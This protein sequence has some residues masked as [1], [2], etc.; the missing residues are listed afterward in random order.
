MKQNNHKK[1]KRSLRVIPF[2][3]FSLIG[4]CLL[5][6]GIF[7]LTN[8][9][10]PE[11]SS[12][13]NEISQQDLAHAEEALHLMSE[14]GD[15]TWPE[16]SGNIPLLLWNDEYAFLTNSREQVSGWDRLGDA[17]VNHLPVY[18]QK[19]D[20]DYQAFTEILPNG[21][22]AGSMATK[23]ATNIGFINLFKENL[24]PVVSQIFPYR[25]LLLSTDQYISALVHESFH[26]YQAEN[27]PDR[28]EDAEKAYSS[29]D[30][31]ED[32]FE[33]MSE[34]WQMEIQALIDALNEE[35]NTKRI[36]L[37]IDF[38][39]IRE[40]RR[41]NANLDSNLTL[42]E[43]RYEWLEGSAKYVE[44]EIWKNAANAA[45][46]QPVDEISNISDFDSY[47]KYQKRWNNELRNTK[48]AAKT[49]G[50]TLFYYSG[51]LQARLLD[52]L[53]PE[54]KTKIGEPGVWYE[55]L[56]KEAVN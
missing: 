12:T 47:Q 55:D 54:W 23:N 46:Y 28:F 44:L 48:T 39:Q 21:N 25:L 1:Q 7:F 24:P 2:I 32:R 41:S 37:I 50:D 9:F 5:T 19:N 34:D 15:Q 4:L 35:D 27:Y 6:A 40:D 36:E 20:A 10:L 53:M 14:L 56:L 22:Y 38:I 33:S 49:G 26:A 43:K 42:Y 51:M 11:P 30:A 16:L 31:Y 45:S 8:Q 52:E 13:P 29:T 3:V 18:V 17:E